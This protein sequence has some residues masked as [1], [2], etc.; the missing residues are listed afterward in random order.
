MKH[1]VLIILLS[2]SGFHPLWSQSYLPF[3][4]SN[5]TWCDERYDNG[6]PVHYYYNYYKTDGKISIND[7]SY[8]IISDNYGNTRCYLREENMKVFCRFGSEIPEYIL[9]D[10]DI[11]V[12]D[13]VSLHSCIEGLNYTGFV[14]QKDS[15]LIGSQYHT[16]YFIECLEWQSV[17]FIEGVGSNVGLMYCDIPWVDLWGDLYCFSLNDTIYETCGTGSESPGNCWDYIGISE[18]IQKQIV[19]YPNPADEWIFLNVEGDLQLE[20]TD[21]A[22]RTCRHS[23]SS[24]MNVQDLE[25]GIYILRI[26]STTGIRLKEVKILKLN[27]R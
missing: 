5:A 2:I 25:Q 19:V 26:Y 23:F 8:T 15:L 4:D 3:P 9:Y 21:L 12:G 13:T 24:S 10:F 22:G 16:R 6:F 7:T 18:Q 17:Q 14:V 20:L 1:L 27:A 11:K